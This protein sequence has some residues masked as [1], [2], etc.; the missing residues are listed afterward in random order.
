MTGEKGTNTIFVLSHDKIKQIPKDHTVTYGRIV[1]NFRPQKPDPNRCRI[2]ASGNLIQYPGELITRTADMMTATVIWNSVLSTTD[3]KYMC[4][5]IKNFYLGTPLDR[6]EYMKMP[7]AVFPKH[8]VDQ[9]NLKTHAL[10]GFV[11]L[12]IRKGIYGLPQAGILANK[13][14]RKRL[15]PAGYYE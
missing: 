2:T 5:D 7:L 1:V 10:K 15:A 6:Y 14:L 13:L 4:L 3:A 9:Y 12:E 11:Y 8:T